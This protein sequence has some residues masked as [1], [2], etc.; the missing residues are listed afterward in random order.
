MSRVELL[1]SEMGFVISVND[2]EDCLN[3]L[4]KS[5]Y[6]FAEREMKLRMDTANIINK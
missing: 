3:S 6:Y 5:V 2:L 4:H 1:S